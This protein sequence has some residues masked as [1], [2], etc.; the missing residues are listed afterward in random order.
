MLIHKWWLI[1]RNVNFENSTKSAMR[2]GFPH[3]LLAHS[4]KK[5]V[6]QVF[7][8]TVRCLRHTGLAFFLV[9]AGIG[10]ITL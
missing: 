2:T 9:Q 5:R 10:L 6:S 3:G 1:I 8:E 4:T 7:A